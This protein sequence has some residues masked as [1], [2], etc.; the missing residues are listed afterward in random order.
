MTWA[1]WNSGNII[2]YLKC[3]SVMTSTGEIK[4]LCSWNKLRL[5]FLGKVKQESLPANSLTIF[6]RA[7]GS[8][9]L[10]L[11]LQLHTGREERPAEDSDGSWEDHWSVLTQFSVWDLSQNCCRNRKDTL[12]AL[13]F[14]NTQ[15]LLYVWHVLSIVNN[16]MFLFI[17]FLLF[18]CNVAYN[19]L[20]VY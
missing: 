15:M 13:K 12:C 1:L 17:N 2:E 9:Y 4:P 10:Y 20:K 6:Y 11:T 8:K 16:C 5:Y 7:L 19:K 3:S 14:L 18:L